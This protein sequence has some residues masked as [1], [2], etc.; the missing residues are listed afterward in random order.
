VEHGEDTSAIA[1]DEHARELKAVK[2]TAGARDAQRELRQVAEVVKN[3][4][5]TPMSI[6]RVPARHDQLEICGMKAI[7]APSR[8]AG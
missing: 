3:S 6:D 5:A 1:P 8:I 7:R 2:V 4:V